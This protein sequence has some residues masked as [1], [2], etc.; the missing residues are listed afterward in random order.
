MYE[1]ALESMRKDHATLE[2]ENRSLKSKLAN[3]D[4]SQRTASLASFGAALSQVAVGGS[5]QVSNQ[6]V[7][8]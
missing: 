7:G 4:K 8:I 6:E 5:V 3:A 2:Q 1:E